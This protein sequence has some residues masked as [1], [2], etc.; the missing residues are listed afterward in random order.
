LNRALS[1]LSA[2][3]EL[4]SEAGESGAERLAAAEKTVAWL[5]AYLRS[6]APDRS[7]GF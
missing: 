5:A 2:P 7:W 3:Q 6:E 4:W 1:R